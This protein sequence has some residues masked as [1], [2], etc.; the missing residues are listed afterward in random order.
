MKMNKHV[1]REKSFGLKG[2]QETV[3]DGKAIL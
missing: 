2:W 3:A 1:R